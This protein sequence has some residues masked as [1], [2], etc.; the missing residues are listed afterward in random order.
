MLVDQCD[1]RRLRRRPSIRPSRS[2]G[3]A[4]PI[5]GRRRSGP[6]PSTAIRRIAQPAD[7]L[8]EA[9]RRRARRRRG[10]ATRS[11]RHWR[12]GRARGRIDRR[13]R[14]RL[15]QLLR[16]RPLAVARVEV[17][18]RRLV[19]RLHRQHAVPDE[20]RVRPRHLLEP[21][22][23]RPGRLAARLEAADRAGRDGVEQRPERRLIGVG[24]AIQ[25]HQATV[26]EVVDPALRDDA[27]AGTV[28]PGGD[29]ADVGADVVPPGRRR[30]VGVA[31]LGALPR[32]A[33]CP[34]PAGRS[35]AAATRPRPATPSAPAPT[36]RA[37][38]RRLG[39]GRE[40]ADADDR[41]DGDDDRR[42]QP[43]PVALEERAARPRS[44]ALSTVR[45]A[46]DPLGAGRGPRRSTRARS[47][48]RLG[49]GGARAGR[50]RLAGHALTPA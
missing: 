17:E 50:G 43:G 8:G 46:P 41:D 28:G 44:G 38:V 21:G 6:R 33:R 5:A 12:A 27:V 3:L 39:R 24:V 14:R 26:L 25:D 49:R 13:A 15:A 36:R 18:D 40:H 34:C 2:P 10:P 19:E 29:R 16:V 37:G 45:R 11:A 42:D 31:H 1:V 35:P 9:A 32:R 22:D 30:A 20:R 47:G 23:E 48:R 4:R 7:Q